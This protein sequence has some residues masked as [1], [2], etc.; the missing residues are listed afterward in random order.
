MDEWHGS[1][2][3]FM[4]APLHEIPHISQS[5]VGRIPASKKMVGKKEMFE[6][7]HKNN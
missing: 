2:I 5:K 4:L 7:E 1:L 6:E 3:F